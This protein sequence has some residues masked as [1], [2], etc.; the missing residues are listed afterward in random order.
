MST[1]KK[2]VLS[3]WFIIVCTSVVSLLV[4]A[5]K[6]GTAPYVIG[7]AIGMVVFPAVVFAVCSALTKAVTKRPI[8]QFGAF[9]SFLGTWAFIVVVTLFSA[10]PGG[11][12]HLSIEAMLI[13][14]VA[15]AGVL[16][17]KRGISA[18]NRSQIIGK[19]PTISEAETPRPDASG[20]SPF[21]PK[22]KIDQAMPA[23]APESVFEIEIPE[24]RLRSNGVYEI[25]H[26]TPYTIV[27]ANQNRELRC[28]AKVWI[29]GMQVG[30]W[31]IDRASSIRVER[32]VN[33]TGRF[34][35]YQLGTPEAHRAG[36]DANNPAIG[37]IRVKFMPETH[38]EPMLAS[39]RASDDGGTGLSGRSEQ[40][41]HLAAAI[42]HDEFAEIIRQVRLVALPAIRPLRP[43]I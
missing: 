1:P 41:F 5:A 32:P 38:R 31:R 24:A 2:S 30:T 26:A 10:V 16:L 12:A 20:D 4:S 25:T 27:L 36:L 13:A 22:A 14:V 39:G 23:T 8:G 3:G 28:D 21:S 6:G 37:L 15:V 9:T 29:D 43:V 34:T 42:R 19:E 17:A 18:F 40:V 33:D 35:F 7:G 11:K